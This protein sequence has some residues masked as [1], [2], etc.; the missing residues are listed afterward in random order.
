MNAIVT[1]NLTKKY[2]DTV[3]VDR[4][5]LFVKEGEL[6][7]LL[8]VNGAGKTTLIKMLTTL[9]AVTGGKAF[10]LNNDVSE[11]PSAVKE[12]VAL[13]P[14]ENAIAPMLSAEENLDFILSINGVKGKRAEEKKRELS[15]LIDLK[16]VGKKRAGKLSGG[17]KRRLSLAMALALEP[18]VLFLDEPTLG[19]DILARK[20]LW[21]LIEG[22]KGKITIILTTHYLE[23]AEALSDR[24]GIMKEGKL[25]AVGTVEEMKTMTNCE[26]FDDAFI[27]IVKGER[28]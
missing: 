5:S 15:S 11:N 17:F 18:K 25:L 4:V 24:V 22:L 6:F 13:S 27:E 10:V 8:G 9:T 16:A 12:V 23:E 21:E 20:E 14:Q 3:A 2:K 1:E 19:L 26:R 7:S 28:K